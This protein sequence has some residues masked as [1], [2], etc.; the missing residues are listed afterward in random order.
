MQ[1]IDLHRALHTR[2]RQIS[3][4]AFDLQIGV[5]WNGDGVI[6]AERQPD[7]VLWKFFPELFVTELIMRAGRDNA[8]K[9][10]TLVSDKACDCGQLVKICLRRRLQLNIRSDLD[11]TRGTRDYLYRSLRRPG[12]R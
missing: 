7:Q 5:L 4:A 11:L 9:R 6:D 3:V 8:R 2:Y 10:E 12:N 1:E